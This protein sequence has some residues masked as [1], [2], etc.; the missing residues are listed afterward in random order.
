MSNQ[1]KKVKHSA[2]YGL[3]I[4]HGFSG[5]LATDPTFE[6]TKEGQEY[7]SIPVYWN[8][9]TKADDKQKSNRRGKQSESD[10]KLNLIVK[11]RVYDEA[12]LDDVEKL[13]KGDLVNFWPSSVKVSFY[14][15]E[16][17]GEVRHNASITANDFEVRYVK[18]A[19]DVTDHSEADDADESNVEEDEVPNRRSQTQRRSS[20]GQLP[21]ANRQKK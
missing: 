5:N 6:L 2:D 12:L 9:K 16:E 11:V 20:R 1:S 7:A 21:R 8:R 15:D 13:N 3:S 10:K 14:I 4:E 17:T 18:G 19:N